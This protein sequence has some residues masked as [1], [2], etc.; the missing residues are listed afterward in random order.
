MTATRLPESSGSR[1]GSRNSRLAWVGLVIEE[2]GSLN[3]SSYQNFREVL[4]ATRRSCPSR[5]ATPSAS[6]RPSVGTPTMTSGAALATRF[7]IASASA[8]RT[9]KLAW[10]AISEATAA[11]PSPGRTRIGS[12]STLPSVS[13]AGKN[14]VKG[15]AVSALP[16]GSSHCQ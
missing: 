13:V 1:R 7:V 10:L 8:S 12:R 11:S 16:A 14:V 4:S 5:R 2:I 9:R 15:P 3:A 6:G